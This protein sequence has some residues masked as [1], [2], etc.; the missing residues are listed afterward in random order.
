VQGITTHHESAHQAPTILVIGGHGFIGRYTIAALQ[1]QAVHIIIGTRRAHHN[2]QPIE[3]QINLHQLLNSNDWKSSLENVDVVINCVGILRERPGESYDSVHHIAVSALASLCAK[4]KVPLVHM[5]ALG[6]THGVTGDFSLSKL[7]GEKA[8][9]GSGCRATIIRASVVDAIDGYGSGWFHQVAQWPI[10]PLPAKANKLLSPIR[11]EDLG[12]ALC[13]IALRHFQHPELHSAGE[14]VDV[15]CGEIFTLKA[16]LSRLRRTDTL[17]G[18]KPLL[19]VYIPQ[20]IAKTCAVILDWLH[21]TPYTSGH[22][23]LLEHDNL[24]TVNALPYILGRKP[25]PIAASIKCRDVKRHRAP[26]RV[27]T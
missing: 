23:E 16:Y 2:C 20:T 12:Q 27:I 14:I 13:N 11:A 26:T 21:L 1:K 4:N 24:P 9:L 15:G 5:S 7:R 10:W 25:T 3:R 18:K 22:H 8:I 6:I 17:F 19:I